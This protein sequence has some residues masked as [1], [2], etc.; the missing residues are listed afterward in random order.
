LPFDN[1]LFELFSSQISTTTPTIVRRSINKT[2]NEG[3][4]KKK[5]SEPVKKRKHSTSPIPHTPIIIK[6]RTK[7]DSSMKKSHSKRKESKTEE[8]E[9]EES[10]KEEEQNKSPVT[11]RKLN[12]DLSSKLFSSH[13]QIH[14]I[15]VLEYK[16]P[17]SFLHDSLPDNIATNDV[18]LFLDARKNSAKL[19]SDV[20]ISSDMFPFVV[21]NKSI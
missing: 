2:S 14:W 9:E 16:T 15:H 17:P 4:N 6:K 13:I 19:I 7:N 20:R 3:S 18:Y 5:L 12:L 8:E 21:L 10:E 11:K 1:I